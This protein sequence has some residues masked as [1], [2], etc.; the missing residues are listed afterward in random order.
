MSTPS[1]IHTVDGRITG[2]SEY[3]LSA[4]SIEAAMSNGGAQYCQKVWVARDRLRRGLQ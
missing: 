1:V 4:A 3:T 2:V